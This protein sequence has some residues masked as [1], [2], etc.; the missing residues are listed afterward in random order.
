[1]KIKKSELKKLIKEE[2]ENTMDEGFMDSIKGALGM[3]AKSPA[4]APEEE[5][6]EFDVQADRARQRKERLAAEEAKC[7]DLN[8]RYNGENYFWRGNRCDPC[9]RSSTYIGKSQD[10]SPDCRAGSSSSDY[11]YTP[12]EGGYG[13]FRGYSENQ[14]KEIV[15]E[16]LQELY[17][18]DGDKS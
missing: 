5:E 13:G 9:G 1:M 18:F 15:K 6:E 2:L 8:D 14:L 10:G 17:P 3:G 16:A 4:P 12:G 7:K 11:K